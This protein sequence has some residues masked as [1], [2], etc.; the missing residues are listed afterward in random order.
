MEADKLS[1]RKSNKKANQGLK[2][3]FD[4]NEEKESQ[5]QEERS[6]N[7]TMKGEAMG[8]ENHK[9]VAINMLHARGHLEERGSVKNVTGFTFIKDFFI[10]R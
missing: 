2:E 7:R 4:R 6:K 8:W 5:M 9:E 1:K 3:V 10:M